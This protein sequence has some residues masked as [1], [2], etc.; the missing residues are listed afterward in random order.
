MDSVMVRSGNAGLAVV[1]AILC[2]GC[3]ELRGH[4]N[5]PETAE[6]SAPP[7]ERTATSKWPFLRVAQNKSAAPPNH[8]PALYIPGSAEGPSAPVSPVAAA[9]IPT[10]DSTS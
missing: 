5:A 3:S 7:V 6:S 4:R 8:V 10:A 9:K 2:A 1:L